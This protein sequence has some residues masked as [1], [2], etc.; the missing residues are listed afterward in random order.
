MK[1]ACKSGSGMQTANKHV[2]NV[3]AMSCE[4]GSE[5]LKALRA[6]AVCCWLKNT[7]D[8]GWHESYTWARSIATA[9]QSDVEQ[10]V[11]SFQLKKRT[12]HE[13]PYGSVWLD[14]KRWMDTLIELAAAEM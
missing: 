11:R 7:A 2:R 13:S 6:P 3:V 12:I 4:A 5:G 1:S 10:W 8:V 14:D 9:A